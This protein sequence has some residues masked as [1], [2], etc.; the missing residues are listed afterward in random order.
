MTKRIRVLVCMGALLLLSACSVKPV[1]VYKY[2][3]AEP[4]LQERQQVLVAP[5][6]L[7]KVQVAPYLN[8]HALIVQQSDYQLVETQQHRWAERLTLQ[9]ERQLR[10]GLEQL[11]PQQPWFFHESLGSLPQSRYVLEVLIDDFHFVAQNK[12]M[13]GGQWLLRDRT[14]NRLYSGRLRQE[15]SLEGSG[16][17][18]GVAVLSQLWHGVLL[19]ITQE[20]EQIVAQ[21]E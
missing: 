12:A 1:T 7:G 20:L 10:Q 3:L 8:G 17:E 4:Q 19:D 6:T 2:L 21:G 13:I 18:H 14:Q 15:A 16:Y 5:I 9:L 11:H